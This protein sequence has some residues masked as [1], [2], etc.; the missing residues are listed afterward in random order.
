MLKQMQG[1]ACIFEK[2][3]KEED[4]KLNILCGEGIFFMPEL[5]FA[6]ACGKAVMEKKTEIFGET[7]VKWVREQDFGGGGPSDLVFTLTDEKKIVVEFKMRAKLDNY[8]ADIK[9]LERF[10]SS[11]NARIYCALLDPFTD[12]HTDNIHDTRIDQIESTEVETS[13]LIRLITPFPYFRTRQSWYKKEVSCVV[14]VWSVGEPPSIH[15]L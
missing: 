6:Y 7:I 8:M 3:A 2:V 5:A 4:E 10:D 13:P 9:K 11:S 15:P 12:H 1:I 14:A